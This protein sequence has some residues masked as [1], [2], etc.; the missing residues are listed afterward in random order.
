MEYIKERAKMNAA[1]R[2]IDKLA[3]DNNIKKESAALLVVK[4]RATEIEDY[5]AAHG[6]VPAKN[7][8][9]LAVQATLIHEGKIEDKTAAGV[10]NYFEA[11]NSVMQDEIDFFKNGMSD[12]FLGGSLLGS[13]LSAGKAGIEAINK[14]KIAQGKKPILSGKFWQNLK[15]KVG[16]KVTATRDDDGYNVSIAAPR[17]APTPESEKSAI[18]AGI[19]AAMAS[20]ERQKKQEF[21]QKNMPYI[22][23]GV[24]AL[25]VLIFVLRKK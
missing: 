2:T 24:I 14:K 7:P 19:D 20:I 16:D 12:N 22:I 13:I 25:I 3:S 1:F 9:S 15:V 17:P 8:A 5:V 4:N 21:L 18:Q 11:E 6:V 23:G 10:P